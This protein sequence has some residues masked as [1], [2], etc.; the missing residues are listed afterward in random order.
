MSC[1][2]L[3]ELNNRTTVPIHSTVTFH[4]TTTVNLLPRNDSTF[5]VL[6]DDIYLSF[7][8]TTNTGNSVTFSISDTQPEDSGVYQVKHLSERAEL[9]TNILLIEI[10]DTSMSSTISPSTSKDPYIIPLYI[11]KYS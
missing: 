11:R 7:N 3:T 10:I 2:R 6:K 1:A 4:A 5:L 9:L 8:Y